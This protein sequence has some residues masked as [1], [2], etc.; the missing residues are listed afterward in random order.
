M[1]ST[2]TK[3]SGCSATLFVHEHIICIQRM[4]VLQGR[5]KKKRSDKA[6]PAANNSNDPSWVCP[7]S[8]WR[9]WLERV[10]CMLLK[11]GTIAADFIHART[12]LC[13]SYA[14]DICPRPCDDP[15]R[16]CPPAGWRGRLERGSCMLLKRGTI[17]ADRRH[18]RTILHC[19]DAS[20]LCSLPCAVA[21]CQILQ[22]SSP[23]KCP[24][25]ND[26]DDDR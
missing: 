22:T 24:G 16:I 5:T 7:F 23:H 2:S 10:S 6:I 12:V 4:I 25:G 17:A 21:S 26:K 18:A 11:R 15:S 9:G 1:R 20:D 19:S 14:S 13:R 8:G 3:S